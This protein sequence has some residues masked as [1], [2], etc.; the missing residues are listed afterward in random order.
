MRT[1]IPLT[2]AILLFAGCGGGGGETVS[3]TD[4]GSGLTSITTHYDNGQ[5]ETTGQQDA[6]GQ[7][8]GEWQLY[9]PDGQLMFEGSFVDGQL[10]Q[11]QAW[12]EYNADGSVR[13]HQSDGP[14]PNGGPW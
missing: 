2:C 3:T 11:S 1:I 7:P 14:H 12:T 13:H 9:F 10:D 5:I 6:D 8:E 4:P